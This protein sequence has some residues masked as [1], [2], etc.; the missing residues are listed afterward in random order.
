MRSPE[1]I[2]EWI[3]GRRYLPDVIE[4]SVRDPLQ[5]FELCHLIQHFMQVELGRQEVEASVAVCLPATISVIYGS[6]HFHS[7]K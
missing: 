2:W 1:L 5:L 6:L 7:K 4:V 3:R